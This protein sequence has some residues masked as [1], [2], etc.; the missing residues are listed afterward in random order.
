MKLK[1]RGFLAVLGGVAAALGFRPAAE[2]RDALKVVGKR[3]PMPAIHKE[4]Q[5]WWCYQAGPHG[6]RRGEL[7]VEDG[8]PLGVAMAD[9]SP[10]HFGYVQVSGPRVRG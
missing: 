2:R 9:V 7:V 6:A 8:K 4:D 5:V 10:G 3:A 1:R